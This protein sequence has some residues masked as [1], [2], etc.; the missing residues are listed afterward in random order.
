MKDA[1]QRNSCSRD[2][3]DASLP[4]SDNV[5]AP[6]DIWRQRE[7]DVFGSN[8]SDDL[9]DKF[10]EKAREAGMYIK[11]SKNAC[12]MFLRGGS[13]NLDKSLD[14]LQVYL[15][16]KVN[17]AHYFLKDDVE[18]LSYV[19]GMNTHSITS[20]RDVE[21]RRVFIFRPGKWE[22]D[23][24]DLSDLYCLSA[25]LCE[26]I[27]T[28]PKS[29]IAGTLV[30]Y[31]GEGFGYPQLRSVGVK[32]AKDTA[33]FMNV[34]PVWFR[35]IHIVRHPFVFKLAYN[36]VYPFLSENAKEVIH[37]HG[38][39]MKSLHRYVDPRILPSEYEGFA[40]TFSPQELTDTLSDLQEYYRNVKSWK[41]SKA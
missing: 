12:A 38:N 24:V 5:F 23:K 16:N 2:G 21:G 1:L 36:L 19:L 22:T 9:I 6:D 20:R 15:Q 18:R 13:L 17:C 26:L 39:D 7:L 37:F 35:G 10:R 41:L 30:V 14:L 25:M 11:D 4:F 31:D 3:L 29:Q 27:A 33:D 8:L 40:E 34:F 32:D 28:E